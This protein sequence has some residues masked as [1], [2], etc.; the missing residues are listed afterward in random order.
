[1]LADPR[2]SRLILI[3][4]GRTRPGT[5]SVDRVVDRQESLAL[6]PAV[7]QVFSI[8]LNLVGEHEP[9]WAGQIPGVVTIP[10]ADPLELWH[11]AR[12]IA[13][14]TTSNT[15]LLFLGGAWLEEDV[16]IAALGG[17]TLGY[18]VRI[19]ADLSMARLEADRQLVLDRLALHGILTTTLR[20]TL[21]EWAVCL[22]C[23]IARQHVQQLLID[24]RTEL[25]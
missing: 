9:S 22:G 2:R 18:D 25:S 8:T 1:M 3:N 17:A 20:Q 19:L 4:P 16:L 14:L 5:V 7:F 10:D 11:D 15:S 6:L 12:F 24:P 21:L 23:P 13:S